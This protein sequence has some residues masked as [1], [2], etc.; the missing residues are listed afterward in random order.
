METTEVLIVGGGG[1]GLT[2]S[3]LLSKLGVDHLLVSALPTTSILPKAHVLNQRTMEI[4]DD[5]G[6]ADSIAERSTPARQMAAMGW[7]AGFAGDDPDAGR[8]I[9]KVESWGCGG[10]NPL[11]ASASAFRSMNLPQIRLEPIL[12]N[13]ADELAP[14]RIRFHHEAL[15][16]DQHDD[17]VTTQVRN[18][19]DGTEYAVRS[20]YVIAADGGRTIA[21][22]LGI[23][24]EGLG[25]LSTSATMH[26]SADFSKWAKDPDGLIRW[27][28]SPSVA[29]QAVLVPMGPEKW[30][31]DS[32]EWVYH[33]QYAG[34]AI[35]K[36][37]DA[38]IEADMREALEIGDHPMQ[39]HKLTRWTLEGV[40]AEKFRAGRVFLMGDA[41]HRHPPTGGLGLT[42]AVQDA[43]NLCWK[44][45][46]VLSG[47]AG[48][49]LLDSYEA[50]RR[51]TD[52][53]NVQRSLEN[54]MGHLEIGQHLGLSREAGAK[55]N[56]DKLRGLF[57]DSS[58]DTPFRANA[59][60]AIRR[61]SMEASE[62]NVEYGYH[63]ASSA[64]IPDGSP[65]QELAD[66]VRDYRPG[67]R[68]GSP[69]PHAWIDDD[70]GVRR[71]IKDLVGPGRFLLIAGE[72]GE[73]WCTAARTV[74]DATSVPIDAIRIGHLD[75]DL[76]D[77][78]LAWARAR[79]ISPQGAVLIRPDRFVAWRSHGSA[80]EPEGELRRAVDAICGRRQ[81]K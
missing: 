40:L 48:D 29:A 4:L 21:K 12:K 69:L 54:A 52:G 7:Y 80:D 46:A 67:T 23:E 16:L 1:A 15:S 36:M 28:W 41:A 77:P 81:A 57:G 79:E 24:L 56:W 49:E 20:K 53:R 68:P 59:R 71:P 75:G 18:L 6:V 65:E 22:L 32:E 5:L 8:C 62:L 39:I 3:M 10:N 37:S 19:G 13:R 45:V 72:E 50:E 78:R 17:G 33:L 38:E 74:S 2:A 25:V 55:A 60:R 63:Y 73:T 47:W 76:F 11:W 42:S 26:I 64:M 51:S 27:I 70:K 66:A 34:D 31:P 9:A 43:H 30:G 58:E 35:W 14:G 44:L 61:M